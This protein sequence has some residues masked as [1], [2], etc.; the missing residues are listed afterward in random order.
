MNK[1]KVNNKSIF[2]IVIAII[3]LAGAVVYFIQGDLLLGFLN[4]AI[5]TIFGINA[6]KGVKK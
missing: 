6:V 1:E 2:R 4:L 5:G 3:F